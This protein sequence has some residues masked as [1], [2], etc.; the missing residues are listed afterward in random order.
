LDLFLTR[1][2][3]EAELAEI[4]VDDPAWMC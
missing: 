4:L 1:E 3:A 2:A